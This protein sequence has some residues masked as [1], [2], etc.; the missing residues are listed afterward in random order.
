[1]P[2]IHQFSAPT[3]MTE[4]ADREWRALEAFRSLVSRST[5]RRR[6][7]SQSDRLI[8]STPEQG[9]RFGVQAGSLVAEL[10]DRLEIQLHEKNPN[11]G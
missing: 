11:T 1:M 9:D 4:R 2:C 5:A 8:V 7:T 3:S 10:G 6:S